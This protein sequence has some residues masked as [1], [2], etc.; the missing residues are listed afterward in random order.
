MENPIPIPRVMIL[1]RVIYVLAGKMEVIFWLEP[2]AMK[3]KANRIKMIAKMQRK[4]V[5]VLL[6]SMVNMDYFFFLERELIKNM[7]AI[8]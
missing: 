7:I 4:M 5:P 1:A 8:T 6:M 3:K 2:S